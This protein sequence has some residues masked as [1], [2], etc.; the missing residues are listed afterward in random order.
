MFDSGN[1]QIAGTAGA[2]IHYRKRQPKGEN[3]RCTCSRARESAVWENLVDSFGTAP[4]GSQWIHVWDRG[5]DNFEAMCHIKLINSDWVIRASKLNR[6][7]LCENG[8]VMQLKQA[9]EHA[10]LLGSYELNLR[11]REGVAAR[12]AKMEL[13][14]VRAIYPPPKLNSKWVKQCGIKQ[15]AMHAVVVKEVGVEKGSKP[16]CWVLLTSLL[17]NSFEDAWQVVEDYEHRWLIEEYHKV[18]KSLC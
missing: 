15:L 17:I 12:T 11:S 18:I 1:K 8:Q 7:V 10:R 9:I 14:V 3:S 4:E 16:I 13:S 5:G 2:L 6:G